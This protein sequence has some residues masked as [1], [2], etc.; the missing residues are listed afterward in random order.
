VTL[1]ET[2]LSYGNQREALW[3]EA[4]AVGEY[5]WIEKLKDLSGIPS[6]KI[7]PITSNLSLNENKATYALTGFLTMCRTNC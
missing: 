5:D 1:R 6:L 4:L 3:T 7:T 2:L